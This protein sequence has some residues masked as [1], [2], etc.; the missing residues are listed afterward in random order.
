MGDMTLS[1]FDNELIARGFDGFTSTE[2]L[3]YVQWAYREVG[4]MAEWRWLKTDAEVTVNPGEFSVPVTTIP[5][6]RSIFSVYEITPGYRR[7]LLPMQPWT[8]YNQWYF[9]DLSSTD[10]RGDSQWYFLHDGQLAFLPPPNRSM[11]ISVEYWKH[12]ETFVTTDPATTKLLSPVELDPAVLSFAIKW[13]HKRANQWDLAL[14]EE[15]EG[16][17]MVLNYLGDQ[18]FEMYELQPYHRL[19][20][21]AWDDAFGELGYG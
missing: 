11:S 8:F 4:R 9:L 17:T 3:R 18:E 21:P 20:D 2:R 12:P 14:T 19:A 7:K 15:R 5:A 6:L 16:Q 1:D 10:S 13:C